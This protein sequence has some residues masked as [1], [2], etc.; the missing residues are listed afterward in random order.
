MDR[1]SVGLKTHDKVRLDAIQDGHVRHPG[2]KRITRF[3]AA[4]PE[5]PKF[6]QAEYL[7]A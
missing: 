4:Y 6:R 2:T 1:T 3:I 5:Q 7:Q